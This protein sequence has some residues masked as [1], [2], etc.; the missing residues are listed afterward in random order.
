MNP[1]DMPVKRARISL[2]CFDFPLP[3]KSSQFINFGTNS[4]FWIY[5][6][7]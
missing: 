5:E 7:V 3:Y 4:K 1:I 6:G 2:R